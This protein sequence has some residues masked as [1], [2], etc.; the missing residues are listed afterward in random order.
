MTVPAIFYLPFICAECDRFLFP[1]YKVLLPPHTLRPLLFFRFSLSS[2]RTFAPP[3]P[4]LCS[5]TTPSLPDPLPFIRLFSNYRNRLLWLTAIEELWH[6]ND[7][8]RADLP[9]IPQLLHNTTNTKDIFTSNRS[10]RPLHNTT[11]LPWAK[12]LRRRRCNITTIHPLR[13]SNLCMQFTRTCC[14]P[15]G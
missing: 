7:S 15:F 8:P 5:T 14:S 6:I 4:S 10:N 9:T 1:D 2:T 11:C 13:S 3:S 12:Y